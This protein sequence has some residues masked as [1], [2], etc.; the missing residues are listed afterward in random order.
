[1]T[2]STTRHPRIAR[3]ALAGALVA[4]GALSLAACSSSSSSS[5]TT[6]SKG[7]APSTTAA[8]NGSSSGG[9][10]LRAL[11]AA[12][13]KGKNATFKATYSITSGGKTSTLVVAQAPPKTYFSEDNTA[14]ISDGTKTLVCTT[15]TSADPGSQVS[16]VSMSGPNPLS[17]LADLVSPQT[18]LPTIKGFAD[19]V[20]ARIAGISVDRSSKTIAGVPSTCVTVTASGQHSTYCASEA[21][22]VLTE[23]SSNNESFTLTDF[24]TSVPDSLFQAPAGATVDTIPGA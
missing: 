1:M 8:A 14:A 2:T 16:C 21:A 19:Q 17:G 15:D 10:S 20:A 23:V 12:V 5:T 22:G 13:E 7:S 11:S 18:I 24:T 3:R 6:T 9:S 4:A